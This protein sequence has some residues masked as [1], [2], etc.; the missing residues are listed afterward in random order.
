MVRLL[1]VFE[2]CVDHGLLLPKQEEVGRRN[3]TEVLGCFPILE[4]RPV[5]PD[6]V[7]NPVDN[8]LQSGYSNLS[9]GL[10]E[11]LPD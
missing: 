11:N 9:N 6:L 7:F 4:E 3:L 10:F 2:P 5:G 1:I 8:Q